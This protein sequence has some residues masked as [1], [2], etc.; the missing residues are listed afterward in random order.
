MVKWENDKNVYILGAALGALNASI[1]NEIAENVIAG[2]RKCCFSFSFSI[3][4]LLFSFSVLLFCSFFSRCVSL[5]DELSFF[6]FCLLLPIPG[7]Q[8]N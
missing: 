5:V 7:K 2:W 3:S 4:Y 6:W 1:T 8:F